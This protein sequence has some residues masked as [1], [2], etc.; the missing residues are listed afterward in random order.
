MVAF[1]RQ[2]KPP[3]K[4]KMTVPVPSREQVHAMST[5]EIMQRLELLIAELDVRTKAIGR[6]LD[7]T[8]QDPKREPQK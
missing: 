4:T 7:A 1:D 2:V 3:G 8:G 6:G 5:D